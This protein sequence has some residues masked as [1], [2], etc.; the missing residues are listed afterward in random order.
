MYHADIRNAVCDFHSTF[1][2]DL[3]PFLV[4]QKGKEYIMKSNMRR[5][6]IWASEIEILATAKIYTSR[7]IHIPQF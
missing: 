7:H 3:K 5:H 2:A 6:G 4:K 1:N